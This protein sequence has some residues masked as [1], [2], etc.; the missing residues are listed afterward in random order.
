MSISI[1]VLRILLVLFVLLVVGCRWLSPVTEQIPK[2]GKGPDIS[3]YTVYA[4]V[5]I[6][7]MPLTEFRRTQ[8]AQDQAKL[9]VYLSLLD[10]FGCQK[11]FPGTFRFEMYEHLQRSAEPKGKRIAIWPDID[12]SD[13][14]ENNLYW[15]DFLR[16]YQFDL[17][18][19]PQPGQSYIL[20]ATFLCPTGKRL[21]AEFAL[22]YSD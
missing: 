2:P 20:Q 5:K 22:K 10:S 6:G 14:A 4:P 15:R 17:D 8:N 18:V 13:P 12:L 16:A 3:V 9:S 19:Q 1:I 21:S 11:K 7:I